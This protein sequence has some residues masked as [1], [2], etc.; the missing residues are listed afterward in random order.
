MRIMFRHRDT[1]NHGENDM[2]ALINLQGMIF[3]TEQ[4]AKDYYGERYETA[5]LEWVEIDEDGELV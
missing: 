1:N 5:I 4:D 3:R 2:N